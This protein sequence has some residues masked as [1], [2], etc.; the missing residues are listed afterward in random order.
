M[1]IRKICERAGY[2]EQQCIAAALIWDSIETGLIAES[3]AM[4]VILAGLIHI[5]EQYHGRV[6]LS[7]GE[8]S[9]EEREHAE[10]LLGVARELRRMLASRP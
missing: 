2:T 8:V 5:A 1:S 10:A 3:A 4:P 9:A 7:R 6:W